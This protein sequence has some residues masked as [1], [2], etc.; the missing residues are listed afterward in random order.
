LGFGMARPNDTDDACTRCRSQAMTS[1]LGPCSLS[2]SPLL[3]A[4]SWKNNA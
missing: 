4:E 1:P 3:T 2:P